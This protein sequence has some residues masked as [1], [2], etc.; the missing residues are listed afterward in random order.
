M[1]NMKQRIGKHNAKILR[2]KNE[3]PSGCN[4]RDKTK[5]PIPGNCNQSNIVYQADVHAENKIMKYFGSTIDFK[6]R[7]SKHKSS[8]N[9][10][11]TMHTTLSS[12]IWKLKDKN[13]NFNV[14]WS[15]KAKGHA[16]SSGSKACDLCLTEKLVILTED[17]NTMLNKRD[18]LLETCRHRRK[19]LLIS[20]KEPTDLT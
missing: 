19:H 12:Y 6:S 2:M 13:V 15:V 5:C 1:T 10:R 14:E 11:P 17:Q 4:C 18:E 20:Q 8:F 7:Y 3:E 16:F 9:K